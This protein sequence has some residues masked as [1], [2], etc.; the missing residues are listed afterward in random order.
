M[1]RRTG[2]KHNLKPFSGR[3][4]DEGAILIHE[5]LVSSV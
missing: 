4:N 3:R 5:I 2:K 1:L